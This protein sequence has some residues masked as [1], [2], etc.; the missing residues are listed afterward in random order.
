MLAAGSVRTAAASAGAG[1]CVS[2]QLGRGTGGHLRC[3]RKQFL[4]PVRPQALTELAVV[5]EFLDFDID[6]T[7]T[8]PWVSRKDCAKN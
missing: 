1:V 6:L 2:F 4:Q 5:F 7:Q 3:G 8:K